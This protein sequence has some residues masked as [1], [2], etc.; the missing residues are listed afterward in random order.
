MTDKERVNLDGAVWL[1]SDAI[2]DGFSDKAIASKVR[3]GEWYRVRRGAYCSGELWRSLSPE[4]Q[5]RVICRAVL[6]R[7][8]PSTAL[9]HISSAIEWG[10]ET[11]GFDLNEVHS[12]RTDGKNGRREAGLVHHRGRLTEAEVQVVNGVRITPAA[13]SVVET[14]TI[15]GVQPALT[16]AN[17]LLHR[18]EL[19]MSDLDG[20]SAVTRN[21]PRSITTELV[22]RLADPRIESVAESRAMYLFWREHVTRPEPQVE[23]YDEAGRLVGRVDF[24]WAKYGVFGE[25]DGKLK[26]LTMR[27]DGESL[28]EFLLREK[29]REEQICALTGW[30]CFRIA[31]EDL[32]RPRLLARRVN[33][34]L[35][36]RSP[37]LA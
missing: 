19:S 7:A 28:D 29:R 36:S 14:C 21:W 24:L 22:R 30:V 15:A 6:L 17:S 9:S 12:T 23:V 35:A 37:R 2:A 25:M 3:S 18:G 4:D 31:W 10:A 32:A 27:R 5:H 11:W 20:Q 8:H 13:R 1:R 16:V 26:Y 34:L 33:R